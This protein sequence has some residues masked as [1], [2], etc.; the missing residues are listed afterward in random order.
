MKKIIFKIEIGYIQIDLD[1]I[2]PMKPSEYKISILVESYIEKKDENYRN[3]YVAE[4][5]SFQ[6][7]KHID[8]KFL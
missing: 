6:S 3:C 1:Y 8:P 7:I 4:K 5:C 2:F